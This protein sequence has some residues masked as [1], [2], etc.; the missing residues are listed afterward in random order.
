[1]VNV[2]F[3]IGKGISHA[4]IQTVN[5]VFVLH[6]VEVDAN[7]SVW[8]R[9]LKCGLGYVVSFV[10]PAPSGFNH[11]EILVFQVHP[12]YAFNLSVVRQ[13]HLNQSDSVDTGLHTTEERYRVVNLF[14]AQALLFSL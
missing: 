7:L 8:S 14:Q 11:G 10:G 13:A 4:C 6:Q 9:C 3:I 5:V 12:H 2:E 1:M